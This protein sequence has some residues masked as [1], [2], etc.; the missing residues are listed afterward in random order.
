MKKEKNKGHNSMS[1]LPITICPFY[2][3]LES[4]VSYPIQQ[5]IMPQESLV[6]VKK[7]E[8]ENEMDPTSQ[9]LFAEMATE[10]REDY[11]TLAEE[12]YTSDAK[13]NCRCP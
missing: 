13:Q 10:A 5:L 8:E 1:V 4:S 3:D 9:E 12:E 7:G 2:Q 6:W 11:L